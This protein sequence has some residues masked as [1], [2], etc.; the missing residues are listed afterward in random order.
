MAD[1]PAH[2]TTLDA[3]VAP[4]SPADDERHR[5]LIRLLRVQ[6]TASSVGVALSAV[7]YYSPDRIPIF[8]ACAAVL[9][10][11]ATIA[12][13]PLGYGTRARAYSAAFIALSAALAGFGGP[14]ASTF[15]VMCGA[16]ILPLILLPRIEARVLVAVCL[17]LVAGTSWLHLSGAIQVEIPPELNQ[18]A[19]PVPWV[20]GFITILSISVPF[21]VLAQRVVALYQQA[22]DRSE[23]LVESLQ[24]ENAE[25]LAALEALQRAEQRLTHAQ[26]LELLG[27]LAGG[28]AHDMNN[29]LTVI[30]GE[31]S[32][33]GDD[34][35]EARQIIVEHANHAAQLTRQLLTLGRRDVLQA[36]DVDLV[37]E[38]RRAVKSVRKLLPSEIALSEDYGVDSAVVHADPSQLAQVVLNLVV[39]ARD[40]MVGGGSLGIRVERPGDTPDFVVLAVSDTGHGIAPE[41][42]HAVFEP[43]FSTK[44]EGV[45]TGLG[46]ANVKEIVDSLGGEIE[47]ESEIDVGTTMYV[48]LP[49]VD[50][51]RPA[52]QDADPAERTEHVRGRILLVDDHDSVRRVTRSILEQ[53]GHS[54]HEASSGSAAIALL[55]GSAPFDLVI[56]DVV[57]PEGGGR[58]VIDHVQREHPHA[59]LLVISGYAEDE[60]VRRG[61]GSGEFPFLRKP[62]TADELREETRRLLRL[63]ASR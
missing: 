41:A 27:Q 19:S 28:L 13:A 46:L 54:V 35:A 16:L 37:D 56:T 21:S 29:A 24:V 17:A 14:Q 63:G 32:F 47:V 50:E 34:V 43:F 4:V 20:S 39:N 38:V 23:R 1:R 15:V 30:Q 31:A 40:A 6:F 5:V 59:R 25:R 26:K 48:R 49:L 11:L 18:A 8:A 53:D 2:A 58:D 44:P 33:L 9:M 62:F 42:V 55:S 10:L 22:H 51:Q 61:M 45:G 57:M 36:K 3:H 12:Y 52:L 60:R 7:L